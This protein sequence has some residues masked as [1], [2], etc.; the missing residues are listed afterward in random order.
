MV[1]VVITITCGIEVNDVMKVVAIHSVCNMD[2]IDLTD[3][4]CEFAIVPV[5]LRF[6][7]TYIPVKS[8]MPML[9]YC[10]E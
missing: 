7:Y 2:T 8:F 10:K 3:Y 6:I 9:Q 5:V 4:V 1:I